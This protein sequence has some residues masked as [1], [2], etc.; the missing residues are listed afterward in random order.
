M[1]LLHIKFTLQ[2]LF[3]ARDSLEKTE[4]KNIARLVETGEYLMKEF[5][6]L[7]LITSISTA[8][9]TDYM[10]YYLGGQSNMDGLGYNKDLP[11]ELNTTV[12]GVY[13][14][15]G[16]SSGDTSEIDGRGIWEELKPGHG[17]GFKS[18]GKTNNLSDRFGVE[19]TF[20][21]ELR[22]LRPAE[23]IA[24]IKYSRSGT[25][26]D[27]EAAG[28]FGCWDP[29]FSTGN[30]VNQYDHF[31][32]TLRHAFAVKDINGDGQEDRLIPTG[33]VWMQGESDGAF[34]E[35][36]ARRYDKNLKRMMDLIRAALRTDDLPV[37]IGR[38]TDSGRDEKDG[39]VWD[40]GDVI[41]AAQALFV[42]GDGAA[43]LVTSTDNYQYSDN[44]HYD[45]AGYIDLG[46]EF[47][48]SIIKLRFPAH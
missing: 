45:S 44:W 13:I 36:I 29:D 32:A 23:N 27:I 17:I 8:F 33:I 25:S 4:T 24:I 12:S 16:N 15:H 37:V 40:Y 7:L 39:K 1:V 21:R 35:D 48:K 18:D 30:G 19:L 9:S 41:R 31:L 43:Y 14:F 34:T 42:A 10:L 3:P 22:K 26:I 5:I 47:A 6:L 2:H 20:A 46:K 11:A 28:R 38:I